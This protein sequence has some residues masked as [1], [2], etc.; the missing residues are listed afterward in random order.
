M[1]ESLVAFLWTTAYTVYVY[2]PQVEYKQNRQKTDWQTNFHRWRT[3]YCM[4]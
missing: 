3:W 2:S 1:D 4:V